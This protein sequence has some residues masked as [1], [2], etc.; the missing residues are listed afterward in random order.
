MYCRIWRTL[1][2]LTREI[3]VGYILSLEK[4]ENCMEKSRILHTKMCTNP[5]LVF[6]KVGNS[7]HKGTSPCDKSLEQFRHMK[8]QP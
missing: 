2:T 7:T 6:L 3:G 8:G 5:G 4:K 1:F